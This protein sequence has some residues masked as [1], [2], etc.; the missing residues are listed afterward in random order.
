M[1]VRR[2]T[3]L[4]VGLVLIL[5]LVTGAAALFQASQNEQPPLSSNSSAPDGA[6]AIRRWLSE[7]DYQVINQS[8][9]RFVVPADA[10]ADNLWSP[11]RL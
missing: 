11:A 8:G 3:V 4:M 7:F 9:D 1:K 6:L 10:R 2:E 5:I